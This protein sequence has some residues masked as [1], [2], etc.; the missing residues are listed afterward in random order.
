MFD[1][2]RNTLWVHPAKITSRKPEYASRWLTY[3]VDSSPEAATDWTEPLLIKLIAYQC[4]YFVTYT[5]ATTL[6]AIVFMTVP[7]MPTDI[8]RRI[9]VFIVVEFGNVIA[10]RMAVLIPRVVIAPVLLVVSPPKPVFDL[11]D[12]PIT[13]RPATMVKACT[14]HS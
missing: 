14:R 5:F 4:L 13:A 7:V 1:K 2:I 11:F 3:H 12:D 6:F 9:W 10:E 8:A